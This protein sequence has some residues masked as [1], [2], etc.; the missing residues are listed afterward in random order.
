MTSRRLRLVAPW[1]AMA[2]VLGVALILGAARPTPSPRP[3]QRAA[4]I[5]A[6]LRC[7]SCQ[8][9]SVADSSAPIAVAIRGIVEQQVAA[10]RGTA[11]IEAFLVSRYGQDILLRPPA[12]GGIGTVWIVPLA[13]FAL[14]LAGLGGFFWR[15]RRLAPATVTDDDRMAVER[16]LAERSTA[17]AVPGR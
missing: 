7:P 12:S 11:S 13:A 2:A 17:D 1:L 5:E 4:A 16:A 9:V 10:G 3:A 14:A 15:R 8:D 6:Q